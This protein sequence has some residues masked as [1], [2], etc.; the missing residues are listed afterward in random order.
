MQPKGCGALDHKNNIAYGCTQ[1]FELFSAPL[2]KSINN[3]NRRTE[4]KQ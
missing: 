4:Q 1:K 3:S 2:I